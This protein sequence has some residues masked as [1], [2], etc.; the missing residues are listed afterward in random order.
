[1]AAFSL[2]GGDYVAIAGLLVAMTGSQYLISQA[3]TSAA[4]ARLGGR[5]DLLQ[6][7]A[8][9]GFEA[10][11]VAFD[12]RVGRAE[13]DLKA[14]IQKLRDDFDGLSSD[15]RGIVDEGLRERTDEVV[16]AMTQ[17]GEVSERLTVRIANVDINSMFYSGIRDLAS[18]PGNQGSFYEVGEVAFATLEL[19]DIKGATA[20]RVQELASNALSESDTPVQVQFILRPDYVVRD[21]DYKK[22]LLSRR[23]RALQEQLDNLQ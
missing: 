1:M 8:T 16:F 21:V 4:E 7:A 6:A 15:V 5:I 12:T 19:T 17:L 22:S 2:S 23:I 13:L 14:D 20:T 9:S 11:E 18:S 10:I 3:Q